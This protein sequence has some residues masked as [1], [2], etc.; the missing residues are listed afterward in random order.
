LARIEGLLVGSFSGA[1]AYNTLEIALRPEN[2]GKM[3]I[4]ILPD[5]TGERYF[6]T[7]FF[8]LPLK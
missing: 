7:I 8:Q 6:S 3:I 1:A 4:V 2:K 5:D